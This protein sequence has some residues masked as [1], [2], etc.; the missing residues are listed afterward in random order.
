MFDSK[1]KVFEF[2]SG[3]TEWVV[4]EDLKSAH[5]LLKKEFGGEKLSSYKTREVPLDELRDMEFESEDDSIHT[6]HQRYCQITLEY[7]GKPIYL[8]GTQFY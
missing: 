1:L 6:F 7:S 5:K 2:Q 4:A 3:E 8:A